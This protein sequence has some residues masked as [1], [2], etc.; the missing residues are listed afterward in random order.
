MSVI[1]EEH[2]DNS[3]KRML[4]ALK[5]TAPQGNRY[6]IRA[7]DVMTVVVCPV[8]GAKDFTT[9]SQVYLGNL[10]FFS[11]AV[12]NHCL[13][14][15]RTISPNLRWFQKCW[16]KIASPLPEVFNPAVEEIRKKHK[17][18]YQAWSGEE[19][20]RLVLGFLA[21]DSIKEL[22]RTLE[23]QVGGIRSRLKKLGLLVT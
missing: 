12:C 11:T 1:L 2:L 20:K 22:A 21:G 3:K 9:I 6:E 10:N 14:A 13:C 19:E 7:A 16:K 8:C 17:G 23:R 15:F 5:K 4:G 18:A